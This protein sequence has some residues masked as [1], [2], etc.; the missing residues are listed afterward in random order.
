MDQ[1]I[2]EELFSRCELINVLLEDG[3]QL[4]EDKIDECAQENDVRSG[5]ERGVDISHRRGARKARI[6]V[7]DGTRIDGP[8]LGFHHPAKS[9]R[10]ALR[11]VG[12]HDE[13]AVGMLQ[14]HHEG[15]SA[16]STERSAQTGHGCA[17]SYPGL[18]FEAYHPQRPHELALNVI[19][20]VIHRGSA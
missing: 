17:V 15:G 19:P 1:I 3:L 5:P 16:A 12:P 11:H 14:V 7:H 8:R 4:L 13:N 10:V 6:G 20:F 9:H 2:V 18:V